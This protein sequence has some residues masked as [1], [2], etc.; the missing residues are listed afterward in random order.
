MSVPRSVLQRGLFAVLTIYLAV[1]LSF[2][3]VTLT[4]D[5]TVS[6]VRQAAAVGSTNMAPDE[7]AEYI[8]DQVEAYKRARNLDEPVLERYGRWLVDVA[9]LDWGTSWSSGQPVSSVLWYKLQYTFGY[10]L[11]GFVLGAVVGLGLGVAAAIR[12]GFAE[13]TVMGTASI[14][15]GIPAFLLAVLALTFV[16]P[17]FGY[18][19][20]GFQEAAVPGGLS[21][22]SFEYLR[23]AALPITIVALGVAANVVR[24]AHNQTS[25]LLGRQFV[26]SLRAKGGD[27]VAVGRHVLRLSAPVLVSLV[28]TDFLGTLVLTVYVVEFVFGLPGFGQ[29]TLGAVL[30]RDLPLLLGATFVVVTVGVSLGVLS[31]LLRTVVDPR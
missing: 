2:A 16:G 26:K 7:R 11:P 10:L 17:T 15:L 12:G 27:D 20:D 24:H 19:P 3:V 22:F 28:A 13:R 6:V 25:K 8:D 29:A 4:A 30:D 5:P 31:D 21:P 23:Y 9:T 18:N 1:S 14:G